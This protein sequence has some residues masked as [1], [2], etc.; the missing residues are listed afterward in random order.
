MVVVNAASDSVARIAEVEA[1]TVAT[2]APTANINWL[3]TDQL[4]TPRMIFDKTGALATVKRHD[5]L[6]FGEELSTGQGVRSTT[7]GYGAADSVRQKFTSQERDNETGLDYFLARYYSSTQGRFTSSDPLGGQI[8]NPQTLNKYVYVR[9]N[10]LRLTDPTGMYVCVDSKKCDSKEDKEFEKARQRDLKSKDPDVVRGAKSYGD[11]MKN[12][13]VTLAFGDPGKG[14]DGKTTHELELDPNDPNKTKF[15]AKETVLIRTGLS[16]A[17][18]DGAVGHEGSH[19]ADAQEFVGTINENTGWY[20][21]S[22]NLSTYQTELR[23]YTVTQAL[24]A[25]GNEHRDFG[26]CGLDPCRLGA[27]VMPAKVI[28]TINR[29]LANPDNRYGSPPNYGVTPG[30]PGPLLYPALTTPGK[31]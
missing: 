11:P 18:L 14:K 17:N 6:P 12:N 25:S 9:N 4:G 19:V 28:E 27:G 23:A 29:M 1:W 5:Y 26:Q 10:P 3:V 15:R 31:P 20:D 13:G 2:S 24:L 30:K 21:L 22:K 8:L 16:G 7:L